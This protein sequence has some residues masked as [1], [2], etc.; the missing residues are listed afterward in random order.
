MNAIINKIV[1]K[2][3][4]ESFKPVLVTTT[5]VLAA[6]ATT[7]S[8]DTGVSNQSKASSTPPS[9]QIV[10]LYISS[11]K[12]VEDFRTMYWVAE[13]NKAFAS[14]DD[15]HYGW[16]SRMAMKEYATDAAMKRCESHL[17][18]QDR[19]C[20]IVNINGIW[21]PHTVIPVSPVMP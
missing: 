17:K 16:S 20:R 1:V 21:V 15:G 2:S 7:P 8:P 4:R 14:S 11:K 18:P 5:F 12:G 9:E 13:K 6:C 19:K 10:S 3:L